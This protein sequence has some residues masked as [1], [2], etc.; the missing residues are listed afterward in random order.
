MQ[1][2]GKRVDSRKPITVD[3]LKRIILILH[4][5]CKSNYE[6]TLFRAAFALAFFGFMRIGEITYVNKNADNHVLKISDIKFNDIDS[7][8]FVTIMSSKTDQI[9]CSTTLILSSN[10]NDNELCV[11][12]MLKDYLQL[13][14]DSQGN[15][16]VWIIGS[17]L[18]AKASSHSQIRPLGNDLGLHKLGYKLMWAGMSGMSVYNVV[19][20]VENLIHCCGLPDAVLLHCG[21]NDIGLVNCGKLLFDIKFML[22]IVVRMVNGG[23]IMFSSILPRLKWRYS[24]DVK[25]MDATRKRINR[26]LNL[27]FK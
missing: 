8:V 14:P 26:G 13:R 9:G 1:R 24:K 10:V 6:T 25:A 11:V 16:V 21:G 22:D 19:P 18:V 5:V 15:F 17:S 12:K 23:K 2:L 27:T 4:H 7:E 3:V 20:I